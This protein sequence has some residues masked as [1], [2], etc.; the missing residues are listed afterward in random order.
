[1]TISVLIVG[2]SGMVGRAALLEALD[3]PDLEKVIALGRSEVPD[4]HPKL[5]QI[6]RD[7]LAEFPP[8]ADLPADDELAA[9]ARC[10]VCLF[11]LGKSVAGLTEEQYR[12]VNYDIPVAIG[13]RLAEVNPDMAFLYV[14]GNGTDS[15]EKGRVMWAR[16][17]GET[18]N[19]LFALPF[20]AYGIRPGYIDPRRG[21]R[22]KT[23][24]YDRVYRATRWLVPLLRR[25]VPDR[26]IDS[27]ELGRAMLLVGKTKPEQRIWLTR[28]LRALVR[29]ATPSGH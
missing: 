8:L 4:E 20:H 3:E 29:S 24:L 16:V 11:A 25:L 7:D 5:S 22:S 14:S 27:D 10:D 23:P 17:K 9:V 15:T 13:R 19:A 6:V 28:D 1:M 2:A 12:A 21:V 18:E 26:I